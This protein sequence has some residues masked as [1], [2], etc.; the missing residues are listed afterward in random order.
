MKNIVIIGDSGHSKVIADIV[1][2]HRDMRVYAKLDDKYDSQFIEDGIIKAPISN[3]ESLFN[4]DA[5]LKVV[6]GIGMNAIREKIIMTYALSPEVF[7]SLIHPSAVVSPSARLGVGTVVMPNVTINADSIIGDHV[8]L[9]T[10][11]VVEHDC[12]VGDFVHISPLAVITGG[13]HV[14]EGSHI[15]AG[16]SVIPGVQIGQWSTVGA[17]AT[18]ITTIGDRVTAVGNPAREIK[19]EG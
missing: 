11:C 18:V 6:L 9:N 10:G 7:I 5:E 2:E 1:N 15:G 14:G 12:V 13:V 4:Q 8:I 16:A 17:G 3:I 19:R